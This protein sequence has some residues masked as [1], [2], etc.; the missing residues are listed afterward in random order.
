MSAVED[1]AEPPNR[2]EAGKAERRR[3]IILAARDLI[4][5]TGDAGLSMR[6]LA[7]RAGVSLATPYNLFGSKRAIILGVLQDIREYSARFAQLPRS[8]PLDR[9]FAAVDLAVSYYVE[10]PQFYRILWAAIFDTSDEVRGQVLNPQREAFWRSLIEAAATANLLREGVDTLLLQHQ[11]DFVFRAAMLD[12][13]VDDTRSEQLAATIK[14]G[15]AL[16]LGG[17][18]VASSQAA[19]WEQVT[20]NQIACAGVA[21]PPPP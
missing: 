13:V 2:R 21:N 17:A 3:R 19:L 10:D 6:A 18:C 20:L 16:M 1:E 8:D 7:D 5:E 15:F 11:L 4:R 9:I 14:L 12:W